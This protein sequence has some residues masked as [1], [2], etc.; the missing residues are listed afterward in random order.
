MEGQANRTIKY[1]N[2]YFPRVYNESGTPSELQAVGL[3]PSLKLGGA[4]PG[5]LFF[6][7]WRE[8]HPEI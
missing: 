1:Y 2:V 7:A 8:N 3:I 5:C 4:Q 6:E